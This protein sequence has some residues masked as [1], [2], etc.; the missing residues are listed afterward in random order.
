VTAFATVR[1]TPEELP[2]LRQNPGPS[3]QPLSAACLKHIDEQTLVGLAAVLRAAGQP[4]LEGTDFTAWGVLAAPRFLGRAALA[5]A[6]QRYQAEGA[7][8]ISPHLIP[9]RSLHALSGTVSQ[10]LTIH[11]PNFGVG[12]GPNAPAEAL[13]AAA[14][15]LAEGKT[16][17]VWVVLTAWEPEPELDENGAPRSPAACHALALALAPAGR[18]PAAVRL[19]IAV[20]AAAEGAADAVPAQELSPARLSAV[21]ES[22]TGPGLLRA[23]V[24]RGLPGGMRLELERAAPAPRTAPRAPAVRLPADQVKAR[25]EAPR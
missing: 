24:L 3:R 20:E 11:G 21:L 6:L 2:A 15:L 4:G 12:G 1:A 22:L 13:L 16:P 14:A 7:W 17:G 25:V 5:V 18:A 10:V 23:T 9:H 8:G 19:R